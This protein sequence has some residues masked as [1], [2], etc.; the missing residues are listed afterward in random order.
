MMKISRLK[1]AI[2]FLAFLLQLTSSSILFA[3]G[4]VT[5]G[6]LANRGKESTLNSWQ[7]L[8]DY[9]SQEL[10][11]YVFKIQ[12]LDFQEVSDVVKGAKVDFI[13]VNSGLY[14][15]LEYN[16]GV[17]PIATLRAKRGE[18]GISLFAG[19]IITRADRTDIRSFRDLKGKHF[20]A[21]D[22]DSLGGWL[23]AKRELI[24]QGIDPERDFATLSFAGTHDGVVKEVLS[25]K[26]DAG[27]IRSDTLERMVDEHLI[28][29]GTLQIIQGDRP[30]YNYNIR[31]KE[32]PFPHS[33]DIYPEWPM[34]KLIG[35]PDKL[36]TDV[37]IALLKMSGQEEAAK[38]ANIKGWDIARN[39]QSVHELYREL[40]LDPYHVIKHLR[41]IDVWQNYW[42]IIISFSAFLIILC[43]LL[44][45]L[46]QLRTRL[47]L[48]NT[49]I[50]HMAM[51][52]PLTLLPNRRMFRF[53]ADNAFAQAKREG[54][55]VYLFLIDLDGFKAVNDTYG[56]DGGDEV[57][58][59]VSRRLRHV[60]PLYETNKITSN[61]S[62]SIDESRESDGAFRAED[63]VARH[64]GD[65]FLSLLIHVLQKDHV[66]SIA[67]R[68]IET[69]SKPI[70][71][72]GTQVFVGASIGI[73]VFPDDGKNFEELIKT[74]D[75]AMYNVKLSGKGI[76]R[77]YRE[78]MH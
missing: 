56:H 8:A 6:V 11:G 67:Q 62:F 17:R 68:T 65:E 20:M 14:V 22:P 55:R 29:I 78:D 69:I 44:F 49:E 13:L 1:S 4:E 39:Y 16:Y 35:T 51:H 28:D 41:A 43:I 23:M 50:T 52:D 37:A 74:A 9:L 57:L 25:G 46:L 47:L 18:S 53:L 71:I 26:V 38:R 54:W 34:A 77:F 73:S 2:Y 21:V 60:L 48:A 70:D 42:P 7:P 31:E 3:S 30:H 33:T 66:E 59:Q 5:I 72:G 45:I 27:T 32:F 40:R 58:R 64:G 24:I 36:A 63:H 10:P 75:I 12:P 19:L 61:G 15:Q 76:Y